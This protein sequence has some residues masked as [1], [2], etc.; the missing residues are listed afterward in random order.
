M[1]KALQ[2]E[3][4]E[5]LRVRVEEL[6]D[7]AEIDYEK[8]KKKKDPEFD[9]T[10][11]NPRLPDD[12][13]HMLVRY[14]LNTAGCMNKGFILEGYPRTENDARNVFQD[15]I[16]LPVPVDAAEGTQPEIQYETNQKIVPQYAIHFEAEDPF[17]LTKAKELPH[18]VIDGTHWNDQGMHRRIKEYRAKNNDASN[19]Q[20]FV[21]GL[22]GPANVLAVDATKPEQDQLVSMQ[23]IIE[24]KGKPCCINMIS[25][26][27][28]KYLGDLAKAAL[29]VKRA[30]LRAE[31][32][33]QQNNNQPITSDRE[34]VK[35]VKGGKKGK[36]EEIKTEEQL[37]AEQAEHE[38]LQE[39]LEESEEEVDEI[40]QLIQKEEAEARERK[41]LE[42][43]QHRQAL[44]D[45]ELRKTKEAKDH[46]KLEE[47]R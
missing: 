6:K 28:K 5:K 21:R 45:E 22:I 35:E 19:V 39:L 13:L 15:K 44:L 30:K 25:D 34:P 41:D 1:G 9:R 2:N 18:N 38:A 42:E 37:A 23:E 29:K 7:Q 14:Q 26:S 12:V 8:T 46:T 17:L 16:E 24:Q 36:H 32:L 4:G 47:L 3:V 11:C 10:T 33:E 40:E 27:D 31:A 43:D 20:D